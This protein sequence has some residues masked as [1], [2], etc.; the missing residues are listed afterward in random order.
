MRGLI[1]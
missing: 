1:Q